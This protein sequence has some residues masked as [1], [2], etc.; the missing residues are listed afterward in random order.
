MPEDF[1]KPGGI[2]LGIQERHL[3][4][5]KQFGSH[6]MVLGGTGVREISRHITGEE[7]LAWDGPPRVSD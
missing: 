2:C 3:G 7:K 1:S 6:Q 4:W 5:R